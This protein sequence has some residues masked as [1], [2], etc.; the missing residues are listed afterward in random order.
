MHVYQLVFVGFA[1]ACAEILYTLPKCSD[2]GEPIN[3]AC[4]LIDGYQETWAAIGGRP[5]LRSLYASAVDMLR[6]V[7]NRPDLP[8][9]RN[10]LLLMVACLYLC[11]RWCLYVE[12]PLKKVF[13]RMPRKAA[14]ASAR[15][16]CCMAAT[17]TVAME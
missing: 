5:G 2:A 14:W 13:T 10:Q 3:V 8:Q 17:Y 11:S 7:A 15:I 1:V 12:A 9:T 6:E 16:Y 4:R